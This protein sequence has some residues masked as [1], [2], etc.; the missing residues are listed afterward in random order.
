MIGIIVLSC[1][2]NTADLKAKCV[3]EV[4]K[5]YETLPDC[6]EAVPSYM[7]RKGD[8]LWL[9]DELGPNESKGSQRKI[10]VYKP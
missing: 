4:V 10:S 1:V 5:T 6:L 8:Q 7:H 3:W 9:C 2:L